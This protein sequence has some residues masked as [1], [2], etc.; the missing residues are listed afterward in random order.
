MLFFSQRQESNSKTDEEELFRKGVRTA[1]SLNVCKTFI[2]VCVGNNLK[3][4]PKRVSS[5]QKFTEK[6]CGNQR[7][8]IEGRKKSFD[9]IKLK[10]VQHVV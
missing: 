10:C 4:K 6:S 2:L 8:S 7:S 9:V 1:Q 3:L 5:V